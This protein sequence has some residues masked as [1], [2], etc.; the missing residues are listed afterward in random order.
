MLSNCAWVAMGEGGTPIPAWQLPHPTTTVARPVDHLEKKIGVGI[1]A[2][3]VDAAPFPGYLAGQVRD[4]RGGAL[5]LIV[6]RAMDLQGFV[7]MMAFTG[8]GATGLTAFVVQKGRVAPGP[9]R[10]TRKP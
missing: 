1:G 8:G 5:P 3:V 6:R 7:G 10:I 4:L 9:G 2:E